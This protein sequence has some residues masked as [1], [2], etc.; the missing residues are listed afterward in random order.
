MQMRAFAV[1]AA[2]CSVL[3][4]AAAPASAHRVAVCPRPGTLDGVS[5]LIECGP[6]NASVKF[7][8]THLALKNGKC[9]KSSENFSFAFGT[10]VAGPGIKRPPN[11]FQ[12]VAGGGSTAMHDGAYSSTVMVSQA[13]KNY[14]GDTVNLK[15]TR[16]RS[17]G[18][19]SGT[20]TWALATK[21]VAV[22]GSFTC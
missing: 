13:G 22:S 8:A 10:I 7:G 21:K 16:N 2:S 19:F 15:L 6:A 20:V 17:A 4:V 1:V 5:V 9:Q 3:A 11:S 18:T 12:I 14:I